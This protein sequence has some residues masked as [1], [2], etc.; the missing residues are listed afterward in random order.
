MAGDNIAYA[1]FIDIYNRERSGEWLAMIS[2]SSINES[3]LI[4]VLAIEV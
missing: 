3:Q 4:G 1:I 2:E